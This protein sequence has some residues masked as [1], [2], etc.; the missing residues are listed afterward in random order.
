VLDGAEG[1]LDRV[2]GLQTEIAIRHYYE[3]VPNYVDRLQWL[4]ERGFEPISIL[5]VAGFDEV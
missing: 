4:N 5:P 1:S 3:G 2:V